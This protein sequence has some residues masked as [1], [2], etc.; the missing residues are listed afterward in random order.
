MN[1]VAILEGILRRWYVVA[2]GLLIAV[3]GSL[4]TWMSVP[5][6]YERSASMLMMPGQATLPEES[7]NPYLFL[8]GLGT[9]ADILTRAAVSDDAV[10]ALADEFPPDT[11]V[12]IAR[13]FSTSAPVI[14]ITATSR[15][16]SEAQV[17]VERATA[18]VTE[19]LR[20]LQADQRVAVGQRIRIQVLFADD[21]GTL[22]QKTR[23]LVTVGVGGGIALLSILA[24]SIT[25]A[26]IRRSTIRARRGPLRSSTRAMSTSTK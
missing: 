13:D 8:G 25:D 22:Q 2:L 12:S 11:E 19:T 18:V 7:S 17:V 4:I 15:L 21:E 16:D 14:R 5:A 10:T 23:I 6:S 20:D 9:A 24:A 26:Q 3:G 1:A